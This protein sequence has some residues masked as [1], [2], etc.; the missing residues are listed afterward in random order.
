MTGHQAPDATGQRDDLAESFVVRVVLRGSG[1][2]AG[3]RVLATRE[4]PVRQLLKDVFAD[5]DVVFR[6]GLAAERRRG[7]AKKRIT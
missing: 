6:S 5:P 4:K 2:M 1:R 3:G 7:V